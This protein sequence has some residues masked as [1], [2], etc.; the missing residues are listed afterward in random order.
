MKA[1]WLAPLA[2]FVVVILYVA[3]RAKPMQSAADIAA[4]VQG[5]GSLLAIIAAIG[6]YAKQYTD[7]Q[8]DDESETRAF[9]EAIREEV[10]AAWD[11]YITEIHPALQ[12]LPDGHAFDVIYPVSTATFPIYENGASMVGKINDPELRRII[13]KTY[14]LARGLI[15]TFQHNNSMLTEHKQLLLLYLQPNRDAVLEAHANA[16]RNYSAKLKERDRWITEAVDALLVRTN[17]WLAG[18]PAR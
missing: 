9:V 10:Q 2:V 11:G 12:A 3:F 17:Q 5:V 8:A 6:I 16:L 18:H 15:S 13:V 7:K 1:R 14:S 4:W